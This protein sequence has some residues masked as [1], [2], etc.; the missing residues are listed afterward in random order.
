MKML[1]DADQKVRDA[2]LQRLAD[3]RAEL[4]A[5]I[6]QANAVIDEKAQVIEDAVASVNE[7][8]RELDGWR[9]DLRGQM[10]DHFD[11][12]SEKW[13]E[14]DAG[15]DYLSW[16]DEWGEPIEEIEV[17]MPGKIEMPEDVATEATNELRSEP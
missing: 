17:E 4:E 1:S 7:V 14:T 15:Q 11:G 6:T 8:I 12:R 16:L 2:L 3:R 9:D 13:Q 5:A 10:Q